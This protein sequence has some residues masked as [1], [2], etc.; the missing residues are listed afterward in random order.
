MINYACLPAG[1]NYEWQQNLKSALLSEF[2]ICFNH[3]PD[4]SGR[5]EGSKNTKF[6]LQNLREYIKW[7]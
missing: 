4:K 5:K 7:I 1:R 6:D 2:I 3:K